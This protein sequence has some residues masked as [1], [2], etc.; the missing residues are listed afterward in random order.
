LNRESFIDIFIGLIGIFGLV[1]GT[2]YLTYQLLFQPGFL[3][4][5]VS[6][7]FVLWGLCVF[8]FTVK[9]RKF[10]LY[11]L[12]PDFKETKSKDSKFSI[13]YRYFINL[14]LSFW[15]VFWTFNFIEYLVRPNYDIEE[16]GVIAII[17]FV[18]LGLS[19]LITFNYKENRRTQFPPS[20]MG[21]D[22]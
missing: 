14:S 12:D 10:Y 18:S 5:N 1:L 15:V 17:I 13:V 11:L 6:V 4:F 7:I 9:V 22:D 20:P 16:M 8:L 21:K 19:F 2:F 3:V